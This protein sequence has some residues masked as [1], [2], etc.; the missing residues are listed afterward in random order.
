MNNTAQSVANKVSCIA[1]EIDGTIVILEK[2]FA[3]GITQFIAGQLTVISHSLKNLSKDIEKHAELNKQPKVGK[4]VD[5]PGQE[6]INFD[7]HSKEETKE[8]NQVYTEAIKEALTPNTSDVFVVDL[9][10]PITQVSE[11]TIQI[12]QRRFPPTNKSRR[13]TTGLFECSCKSDWLQVEFVDAPGEVEVTSTCM[14][15]GKQEV[16]TVDED[17][18][19][20]IIK[21]GQE[22][23]TGSEEKKSENQGPARKKSPYQKGIRTPPSLPGIVEKVI[24]DGEEVFKFT[25][26]NQVKA[27]E[28]LTPE[29]EQKLDKVI[30]PDSQVELTPMYQEVLSMVQGWPKEKLVKKYEELTSQVWTENLPA[31]QVQQEVVN[32]LVGVM[33]IEI[34]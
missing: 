6:L 18:I 4:P 19:D 28:P 27:P 8:L 21:K 22:F 23:T 32:K 12:S 15:C 10:K 7:P 13:F 29:Q 16:F 14:A 24:I 25:P 2:E 5:L 11:N 34:S 30:L 9:N 1:A 3:K 26:K 20:K 33:G 17:T 31:D